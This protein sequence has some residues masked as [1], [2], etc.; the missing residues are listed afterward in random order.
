[1]GGWQFYYFYSSSNFFP[2][3]ELEG[4]YSLL[5]PYSWCSA[6]LAI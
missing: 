1:M 6:G 4:A 5:I 3:W 2:L